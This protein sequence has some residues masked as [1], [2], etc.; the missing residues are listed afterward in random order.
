MHRQPQLAGLL[1]H[2]IYVVNI[3]HTPAPAVSALPNQPASQPPS[4]HHLMLL[5]LLLLLLLFLHQTPPPPRLLP[6]GEP[7]PHL[8][9]S[10]C[11]ASSSLF[12]HQIAIIRRSDMGKCSKLNDSLCLVFFTVV[13]TQSFATDVHTSVFVRDARGYCWDFTAQHAA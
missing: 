3:G 4:E 1:S 11:T 5:L 10:F 12:L 2:R 7:L 8:S 13:Y 9:T 6:A